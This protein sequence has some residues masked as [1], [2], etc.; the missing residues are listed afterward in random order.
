M[1]AVEEH[2]AHAPKSVKCAVITISDSRTEATDESGKILR[3]LVLEAGHKVLFTAVVKDDAK[4]IEEAVEQAAWTCDAIVTN[5]GTG[6]GPR[7]VT[8]ETLKPRLDKMLPG[9]G[10]LFRTLS[11]RE[12][13]SAAML[14]GALAGV[15]KARL[16]FCLPGSPAACTLA[17]RSLILPEL[18]H[19]IGV[20]SR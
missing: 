18:G 14:S 17:M 5:G 20:M 13:G 19:A 6:L 15:Y 16:L 9:F 2:K 3:Q 10:E 11:Y 4:A 1:G 12:I 8:I 7:D